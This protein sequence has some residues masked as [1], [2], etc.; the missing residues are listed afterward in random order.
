MLTTTFARLKEA[1][2]CTQGYKTLGEALGGISRYGKNTPITFLQI[3][4]ANGVEDTLWAFK[5]VGNEQ[6]ALEV[7]RFMVLH[8]LGEVSG[9]VHFLETSANSL[10]VDA[11]DTAMNHV[12]QREYSSSLYREHQRLGRC[13]DSMGATWNL[14]D[15]LS[16]PDGYRVIPVRWGSRSPRWT[17][18][19]L[20]SQLCDTL[21]E[22]EWQ[23]WYRLVERF[24]FIGKSFDRARVMR[25]LAEA[26]QATVSPVPVP[27]ADE[28]STDA[29]TVPFMDAFAAKVWEAA[30]DKCREALHGHQAGGLLGGSLVDS[31]LSEVRKEK[32]A[33]RIEIQ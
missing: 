21:K 16:V 1:H 8:L 14:Y 25:V 10:F 32:V 31:L 5:T 27:A 17:V 6:E 30:V 20:L 3:L 19:E 29:V 13:I 33:W 18:R 12:S 28:S 4:D 26:L 22:S 23:S 15:R 9:S 7:A 2:A 11:M 24:K